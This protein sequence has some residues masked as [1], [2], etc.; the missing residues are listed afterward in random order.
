M[1]S[2]LPRLVPLGIPRWA[3]LKLLRLRKRTIRRN[4]AL[5]LPRAWHCFPRAGGARKREQLQ[6]CVAGALPLFY[7]PRP[8]RD[9]APC[10]QAGFEYSERVGGCYIKGYSRVFHQGSTD[11][12]GGSP[13]PFLSSFPSPL[14]S[15]ARPYPL[16]FHPGFSSPRGSCILNP[17]S[18]RIGAPGSRFSLC[19]R[20]RVRALRQLASPD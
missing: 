10:A 20:R 19:H 14:S 9:V 1:P 4:G 17:R 13:F 2:S 5:G 7:F 3:D 6:C 15:A 16:S 18:P 12:R 11:H 8:S